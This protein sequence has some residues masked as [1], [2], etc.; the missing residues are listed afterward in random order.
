MSTLGHARG[1][2]NALFDNYSS[3]MRYRSEALP[4]NQNEPWPGG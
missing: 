2:K 4:G 1:R 3:D